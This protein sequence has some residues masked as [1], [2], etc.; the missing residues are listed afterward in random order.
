MQRVLTNQQSL[1]YPIF[2]YFR[3]PEV[4]STS[5]VENPM[6]E[7]FIVLST[8]FFTKQDGYNAIDH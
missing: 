5:I 6:S 3:E 8:F 4:G 2:T 7:N 1:R